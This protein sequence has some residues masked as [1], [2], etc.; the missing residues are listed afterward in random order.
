VPAS[1]TLK[2]RVLAV[3]GGLSLVLCVTH[4]FGQQDC[5]ASTHV[6]FQATPLGSSCELFDGA[7]EEVEVFVPPDP[8]EPAV[9]HTV[10]AA[11][12]SDLG[13]CTPGLCQDRSKM[14]RCL[15]GVQGWGLSIAL[16]DDLTLVDANIEDAN[17]AIVCG[18]GFRVVELVDPGQL[19]PDGKPQGQGVISAV[20]F[21]CIFRT[22]L[23]PRGTETVLGLTVETKRAP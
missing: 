17:P 2:R 22:T 7:T 18:G 14:G 4:A 15:R 6:I 20:A 21:F 13:P 5:E 3:A 8:D 10:A 9:R 23:N 19:R 12:T 1:T 11:I 16:D